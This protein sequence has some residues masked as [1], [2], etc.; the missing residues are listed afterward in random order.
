MDERHERK[1]VLIEPS[2]FDQAKS[3]LYDSV[4][5]LWEVVDNLSRLRPKETTDYHVS[6][7][8]SARVT[9]D[10]AEYAAIRHLACDL[11]KMGCHIV[12]GGGPGLMQAANEGAKLGAPDDPERSVGIRIELEFEQ[13]S[14]PF[15]G[16]LHEH[17][18]FFSRLH[19]FVLRSNGFVVV[20]GGIGTSLELMMIWQLLQVRKLHSTPLV[21]VGEMWSELVEWAQRCMVDSHPQFANAEDM[22]IPTCVDD[23]SQA[24]SI[25]Q[26]DYDRWL[27]AN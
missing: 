10:L 18:T 15:V 25:I 14:N 5:R 13:E 23:V 6:I 9:R 8:G 12:T 24:V 22:Q 20:G 4:L 11:V 7:F 27:K 26:Q 19:H 3:V 2:D 1:P 17:K 16:E 21:L